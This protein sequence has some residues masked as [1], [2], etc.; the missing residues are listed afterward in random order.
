LYVTSIPVRRFVLVEDG[1]AAGGDVVG[2]VTAGEEAQ[3]Q[4]ANSPMVAKRA[5][6]C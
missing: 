4:S 6:E 1:A 3:E 2:A 5:C